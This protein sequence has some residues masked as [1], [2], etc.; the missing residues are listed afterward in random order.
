MMWKRGYAVSGRPVTVR[1]C[2]RGVGLQGA[3]RHDAALNRGVRAWSYWRAGTVAL[4]AAAPHSTDVKNSE[5]QALAYRSTALASFDT[6][7]LDVLVAES[8]ARN[9]LE[10]VTGILLFDGR[11]FFQY[12]E[13]PRSGI[14]RTYERIKTSSRH[15][16]TQVVYQGVAPERYFPRWHMVASRIDPTSMGRLSATQWH[17]AMASLPSADGRSEGLEALLAFWNH[18]Q[19]H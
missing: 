18:L 10:S 4:V 16:I 9:L 2:A 19:A 12:I 17:R 6:P 8:S 15:D 5:V 13:G 7:Q 1:L 3:G 11:D 14:E